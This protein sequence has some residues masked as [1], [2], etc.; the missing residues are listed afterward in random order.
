M[1]D[2]NHFYK[3]PRKFHTV[4][5]LTTPNIELSRALLLE[6]TT[7]ASFTLQLV[8]ALTVKTWFL[9]EICSLL[10]YTLDSVSL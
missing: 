8:R 1:P 9:F 2:C 5:E 4:S 10:F 7:F 6:Q 3:Q